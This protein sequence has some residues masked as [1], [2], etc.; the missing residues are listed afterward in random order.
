MEITK[1]ELE[2]IVKALNNH[3]GGDNYV[4]DLDWLKGRIALIRNYQG[5]CPSWAGDMAFVIGGLDCFK[6]ILY[7]DSGT[8]DWYV[9]ET[10]HEGEY[11]EFSN[12]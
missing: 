4:M 8:E 3:D 12:E 9:K 11:E 5:D 10:I 1:K 2:K 6:N 7:R